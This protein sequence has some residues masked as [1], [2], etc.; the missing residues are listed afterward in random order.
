MT[1]GPAMQVPVYRQA[2]KMR[3]HGITSPP[4]CR[5][6]FAPLATDGPGSMPFAVLEIPGD[7]LPHFVRRRRVK[8]DDDPAAVPE[9]RLVYQRGRRKTLGAAE[10][11]R[12]FA[13]P[14]LVASAEVI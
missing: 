12:E 11:F 6:G 10:A 7:G 13:D 1:M 8:V 3:F 4:F 14:W 5:Y 9:L 2:F